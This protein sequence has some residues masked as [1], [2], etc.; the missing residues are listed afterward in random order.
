[1]DKL[2]T[3]RYS[4]YYYFLFLFLLKQTSE[5]TQ[6]DVEEQ[7]VELC[8]ID[9]TVTGVDKP[10]P[11]EEYVLGVVAAEMPVSFHEEALKAQA[12]AARTYALRT[13]D[14]GKSRLPRTFP[15]K[16]IPN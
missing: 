13:T 14:N 4:S 9:I 8:P 5:I 15:P 11:L 1:M 12:I 7:K 10:V 16:S 3:S 6:R 2:L